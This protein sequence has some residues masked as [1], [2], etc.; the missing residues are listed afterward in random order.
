MKELTSHTARLTAPLALILTLNAT[1][2]LATTNAYASGGKTTANCAHGSQRIHS[3]GV[4]GTGMQLTQKACVGKSSQTAIRL[5]SAGNGGT[6]TT[7]MPA[8]TG[9]LAPDTSAQH[10]VGDC[11]PDNS[12]QYDPYLIAAGQDQPSCAQAQE[13]AADTAVDPPSAGATPT[14][15]TRPSG[16]SA[17]SSVLVVAANPAWGGY[18][19]AVP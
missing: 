15:Q 10:A 11:L 8:V 18:G 7:P 17:E 4:V 1:F 14:T 13:G 9:L 6:R 5:K 19:P 3:G 12:Y 2:A 16:A